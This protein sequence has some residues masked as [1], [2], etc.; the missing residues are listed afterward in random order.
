MIFIFSI[1]LG[2]SALSVFQIAETQS[3]THTH[4]HTHTHMSVYVF[5]LFLTLSSIMLRHKSPDGVPRATQ[6][7]LLAYPF[8]MQE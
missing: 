7:H 4:T 8:Q 1:I 5:I 3:H 6:Q 2:Y